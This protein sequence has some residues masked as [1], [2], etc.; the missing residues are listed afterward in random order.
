[1]SLKTGNKISDTSFD[2]STESE[3]ETRTKK[4]GYGIFKPKW[5]QLL[6]RAPFLLV[7]LSLCAICQGSIVNGFIST[8]ISSIEKRFSLSSTQS[9]IFSA[10]YD[11]AIVIVLI[12]ISYY[13]HKGIVI[14]TGMVA[15]GAGSILLVLPH[16]LAGNYSVGGK[17]K[18]DLCNLA[19]NFELCDQ[20]KDVL[21]KLWY[22]I[23][24]LSQ[25]FIGIGAAPLFTIGIS[26]M[27]ENIAHSRTAIYLGVYM[28]VST[29][30][31]ALGFI[32]GGQLLKIWGDIGKTNYHLLGISGPSDPRWYG[33][34]WIGF[35]VVGI[36]S[37]ISAIPLYGFPKELPEK[38]KNR[39]KD[40]KQ[41]HKDL[42]RQYGKSFSEYIKAVRSLLKNPTVLALVLMQTT[43]AF[44][45]NGFITFIPKVFENL[46]NY[47]A[48]YA[49]TITGVIVVP[50]GLL[51]SLFGAAMAKKVMK[52]RSMIALSIAFNTVTLLL[53]FV[54]FYRCEQLPLAGVAFDYNGEQTYKASL[55]DSC[56]INCHCDTVYDPICNPETGISYYSPCFAGCLTGLCESSCSKT[57]FLI[58]FAIL[59]FFTF[60]SAIP[61]QNAS[62]RV[63]SFET[64][65]ISIGL[66]WFFMR[67]LGSIPGAVIF[68]FAID[69]TC[70]LWKEDCGDIQS[71]LRY[72]AES[73]STTMFAFGW[74]YKLFP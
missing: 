12:P 46:F 37:I 28:A 8:S 61:I 16:F 30:G 70:V 63:V 59:C 32:A 4:F 22:A 38:Q 56:N 68:G 48:S 52:F 20:S 36:L 42:D 6:N 69:R 55:N 15:V 40:I 31:P 65:D 53:C 25:L 23:L 29:I 13:G 35:V 19:K 49:S 1:M 67:V 18:N 50:M 7:A 44:L 11:V 9:G 27:D 74:H 43:E 71:C 62:L 54:F 5:L 58:I 60:S 72:D 34:W 21:N 73:L 39:L 3:Y 10:F 45:M 33:A 14:A 57:L 2:C 47:T 66:T 24:L 17:L 41:T 64:R 51:G 26:Y